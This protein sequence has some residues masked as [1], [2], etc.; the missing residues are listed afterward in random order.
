MKAG[1]EVNVWNRTSERAQALAAEMGAG[2]DTRDPQIVVNATTVGLEAANEV[3]PLVERGEPDLKP[4]PLFDDGLKAEVVMDLV[5][6]SRETDLIE[7]ARAAGAATVDGLEILAR[8]GAA[9]LR[10]WTGME[11]P[12]DTMRAA[13]RKTT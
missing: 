2:L 6:G 13:A 10:L 4:F 8:Q 3:Q 12:L 7:A 9:S 1:A 5:Y 11:P